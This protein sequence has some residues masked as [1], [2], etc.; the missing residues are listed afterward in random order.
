MAE[1]IFT[2]NLRKATLEARRWEKAKKS[3]AEVRKFL[4]RHMKADK[5]KIGK[6]V[7]EKIWSGGNQNPP[8]KIRIRAIETE[9]EKKKIVRAELVSSE[10]PKEKV[11]EE[12]K[13][14][15]KSKEKTDKKEKK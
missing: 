4:K 14:E 2:I 1:R 6:S 12:P 11:P 10:T 9:E 13:K 7:S 3:V 15:I 8:N 5:I